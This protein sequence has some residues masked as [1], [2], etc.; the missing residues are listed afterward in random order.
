MMFIVQW[1]SLAQPLVVY[2][3]VVPTHQ[4]HNLQR[5]RAPHA[6]AAQTTILALFSSGWLV[7]GGKLPNFTN[8]G[9]C[10]YKYAKYTVSVHLL[11][12]DRR[13]DHWVNNFIGK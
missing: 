8:L 2:K 13:F 1:P 9:L 11:I 7:G 6:H 3:A 5:H 4:G 10:F 12:Y